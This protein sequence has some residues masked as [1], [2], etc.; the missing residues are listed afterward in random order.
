[1]FDGYIRSPKGTM[2]PLDL[3][4]HFHNC[5]SPVIPSE[6]LDLNMINQASIIAGKLNQGLRGYTI[7]LVVETKNPDGSTAKKNEEKPMTLEQQLLL[8]SRR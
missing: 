7:R 2:I 8:N 3:N 4:Y 5:T 6:Q 1:M